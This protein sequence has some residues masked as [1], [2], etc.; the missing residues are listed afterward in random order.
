MPGG[1]GDTVSGIRDAFPAICAGCRAP[2]ACT[3]NRPSASGCDNL[4]DA[5]AGN[6]PHCKHSGRD[7]TS[8]VQTIAGN[9]GSNG[10]TSGDLL[11]GL[12]MTSSGDQ[13][14]FT[15]QDLETDIESL[16]RPRPWA[17]Q[18]WTHWLR[19]TPSIMAPFLA[20]PNMLPKCKKLAATILTM[21]ISETPETIGRLGKPGEASTPAVAEKGRENALPFLA[22]ALQAAPHGARARSETALQHCHG[23]ADRT[24]AR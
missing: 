16:P 15:R 2:P 21:R 11:R 10:T 23:E 8:R 5:G 13:N 9:S 20:A 3:R 22:H 6:P 1:F 19:P 12:A 24:S 4:P 14:R 7:D 17:S 18:N